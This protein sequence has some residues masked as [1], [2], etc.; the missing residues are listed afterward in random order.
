M[1]GQ[2]IVPIIESGQHTKEGE[3]SEMEDSFSRKR[4]GEEP[5]NGVRGGLVELKE[6]LH[7]LL[8]VGGDEGYLLGGED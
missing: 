8:K 1:G 5:N 2:D 6:A 7:V 4:P 3:H